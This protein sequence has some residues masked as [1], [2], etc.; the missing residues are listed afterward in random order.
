MAALIELFGPIFFGLL[1]L[2]ASASYDKNKK[3]RSQS[4]WQQ[5]LD[6]MKNNEEK[7]TQ[8]AVSN[9]DTN[10]RTHRI[11]EQEQRVNKH[12]E[13]STLTRKHDDNSRS[14]RIWAQEQRVSKH[15][16]SKN[17]VRLAERKNGI[18]KEPIKR[19]SAT[20]SNK[21]H[22]TPV[23]LVKKTVFRDK[24]EVQRAIV[25]GEILGTPVSRRKHHK[26]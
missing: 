20:A 11:W 8:P 16:E 12:S 5:A 24:D 1:I 10:S 6:S 15:S 26:L 4:T 3:A 19:P 25:F 9:H 21:H 2:I 13:A 18:K 22:Q 23:R 14:H 7:K 17:F